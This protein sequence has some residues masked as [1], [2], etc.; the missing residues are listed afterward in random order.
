MD[1]YDEIKISL[2][3]LFGGKVTFSILINFIQ[4]LGRNMRSCGLPLAYIGYQRDDMLD[5]LDFLKV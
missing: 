1:I 5:V 2:K 3:P 4:K